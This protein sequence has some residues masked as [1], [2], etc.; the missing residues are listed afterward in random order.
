MEPNWKNI[1]DVFDNE[2]QGMTKDPISLQEL[3]N[4]PERMLN[5]LKAHFTQNDYD[6]L[7][8]F[9]RGDPDWSILVVRN[10]SVHQSICFMKPNPYN[11][12]FK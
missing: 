1:S 11:H 3:T 9:K 5:A 7:M 6:F 4:T 8:S 2:F 10:Y 12:V